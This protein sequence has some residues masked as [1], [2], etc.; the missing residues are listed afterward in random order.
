MDK[1]LKQAELLG[2]TILDSDVYAAMNKAELAVTKDEE[3]VNLIAQLSEKRK[4][5]ED[6]LSSNEM[7][8]QA[9]AEAGEEM[10]ALERQVNDLP[11]VKELQ[12]RRAEFSQMMN[13]VNQIIRFVLTGEMGDSGCSGS[14]STC[15]G[16]GH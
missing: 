6:I 8:H 11:L 10:E 1:V 14:C 7:D 4:K 9:L 3:S 13:N 2:Q 12:E 15:S 16:C 5:V